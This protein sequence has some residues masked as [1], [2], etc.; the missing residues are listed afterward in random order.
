[1]ISVLLSEPPGCPDL[2]ECTMRM[3]SRLTCDAMRCSSSVL[4]DISDIIVK[5]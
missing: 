4:V 3:M 2:A 1:M 5:I